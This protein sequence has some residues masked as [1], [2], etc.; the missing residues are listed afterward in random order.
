MTQAGNA[1]GQALRDHRAAHPGCRGCDQ[2]LDIARKMTSTR[3]IWEG[4]R[5]AHSR[6]S[7]RE[8]E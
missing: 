6:L 5:G 4:P 7:I 2:Y 3:V 1:L 8:A